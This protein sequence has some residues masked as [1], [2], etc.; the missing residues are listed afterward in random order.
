MGVGDVSGIAS[1]FFI[2]P[3]DLS[4]NNLAALLQ[5]RGDLDGAEPL[6]RRALEGL[7]KLLGSAHP[8]TKEVRGNLVRLLEELG[9]PDDL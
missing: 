7:E 2:Q 1:P 8:T 6:L 5:A 9:R 4:V 3:T